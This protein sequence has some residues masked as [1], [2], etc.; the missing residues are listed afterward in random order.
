M[1]DHTERPSILTA[2]PVPPLSP[3]LDDSPTDDDHSLQDVER[4]EKNGIDNIEAQNL[5]TKQHTPSSR[6][7]A[8]VEYTVPTRTKLLYLAGYF[9]LNLSLT[10]YNKAVLGGV[11]LPPHLILAMRTILRIHN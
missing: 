7:L 11:C 6:P 4:D 5:L 8:A 9:A 3:T 2:T 10:I 1:L